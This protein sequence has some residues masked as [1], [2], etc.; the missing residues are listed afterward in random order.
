M[1]GMSNTTKKPAAGKAV[2]VI[3]GASVSPRKTNVAR[4]ELY[5]IGF[6][7]STPRSAEEA[8]SINKALDQIENHEK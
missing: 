6:S 3:Q 2:K 8:E 4:V 1:H 5:G 7:S